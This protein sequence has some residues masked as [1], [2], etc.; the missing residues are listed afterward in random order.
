[1]K[2]FLC[3]LASFVLVFIVCG[4]AYSTP[5]VLTDTIEFTATGTDSPEDD[6]RYGGSDVNFLEGSGDYL[7]WTH[8]F[9]FDPPAEE[10]LSGNLTLSLRDD[11]CDW[12]E[13]AVSFTESKDFWFGEVDE[14]D[15]SYGVSAKALEDGAFTVALVS[16]WGDFYIDRSTLEIT[17]DPIDS[18]NVPIPEPAT[19]LLFGIGLVGM[20]AV[21]RRRVFRNR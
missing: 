16:L 1:M 4:T 3:F 7:V 5:L 10:V 2:K 20:A 17:Y 11:G 9:D 6:F 14:G 15:Y 8:H 12:F 21:G 18:G 13:V 19:M